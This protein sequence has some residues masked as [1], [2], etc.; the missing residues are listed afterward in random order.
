M[1][2]VLASVVEASVASPVLGTTT[3]HPK[4]RKPS[5]LANF[6]TIS[7][8]QCERYFPRRCQGK[9]PSC[10]IRGCRLSSPWRSVY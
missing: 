7:E 1:G 3:D 6:R 4:R 5:V 8:Q 9:W 2:G 10:A